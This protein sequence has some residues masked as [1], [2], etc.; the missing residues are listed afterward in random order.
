MIIGGQSRSSRIFEIGEFA[1]ELISSQLNLP[2]HD[3]QR[4]LAFTWLEDPG[5]PVGESGMRG[6]PRV[7]ASDASA[8]IQRLKQKLIQ[9]DRAPK[10]EEAFSISCSILQTDGHKGAREWNKRAWGNQF[11]PEIT[12]DNL[13][14]LIERYPEDYGHVDIPTKP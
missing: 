11:D 1:R 6:Q 12:R 10:R 14:N 2:D 7:S 3:D 13:Q 4:Q 8:K 9:A 5:Y